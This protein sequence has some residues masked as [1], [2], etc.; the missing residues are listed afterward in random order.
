MLYKFVTEL[1]EDQRLKEV[2]DSLQYGNHKS[3]TNNQRLFEKY[4]AKDVTFGFALPLDKTANTDI[5]KCLVQ[6]GGLAKQFALSPGGMCIPQERLTHDLTFE[7]TGK[8]IS[9][10]NCLNLDKY[11]E[12]YYGHCLS[13]VIHFIV[14]L[15]W[16]FPDKKIFIAKFDFLLPTIA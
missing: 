9:V 14:A 13:Q 10:N 6:H 11:P 2:E 1:D 16:Q 7:H 12:M 15:C 3:A 4:I 5:P 8:N